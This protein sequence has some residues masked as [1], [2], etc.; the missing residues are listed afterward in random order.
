MTA[1]TGTEETAGTTEQPGATEEALVG[2]NDAITTET[3]GVTLTPAEE[4][5]FEEEVQTQV[6]ALNN[7]PAESTLRDAFLSIFEEIDLPQID[8]FRLDGEIEVNMDLSEF[9]FLSL[10]WICSLRQNLQKRTRWTLLLQP[11][12]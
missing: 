2:G 9:R 8:F 6:D 1:A 3:V 10:L 12:I 7:A 11:T 5:T 4:G